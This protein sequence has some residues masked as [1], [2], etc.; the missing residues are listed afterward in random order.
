MSEPID[1]FASTMLEEAKRFLEKANDARGQQGEDAFLHAALMLACCA[2]EAHV[3]AV[4]NEVAQR[5]GITPQ[6]LAVLREKELRLKDGEFVEDKGLKIYRLEDRILV[7]HRLGMRPNPN[8][9]WRP[10]LTTTL[11][12]RN[13]LTHPKAVPSIGAN[14]VQK[15]LQ[16]IID[17]IDALYSAVYRKRFPAAKRQLD[18]SLDF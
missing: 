15:A 17:T 10:A 16:A 14:D 13:K 2:L 6:D 12:L 11:Q 8:G 9:P 3:N 18:S 1:E 7:L 4:A 5:D